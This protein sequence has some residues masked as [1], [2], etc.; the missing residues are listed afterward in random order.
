[1]DD[2]KKKN[3]ELKV[4]VS[5]EE[6]EMLCLKANNLG[7]KK[8]AYLRRLIGQDVSVLYVQDA[9]LKEY[10]FTISETTRTLRG[11]VNF[12]KRSEAHTMYKQDIERITEIVNE[13]R[14]MSNEQLKVTYANRNKIVK[15]KQMLDRF[16]ESHKLGTDIK[17][18]ERLMNKIENIWIKEDK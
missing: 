4:V 18:F 6:Y 9:D 15:I 13:L 3:R 17:S 16:I 8:A 10:A 2:E 12:M 11:I 5:E 1:M 7:L 14:E